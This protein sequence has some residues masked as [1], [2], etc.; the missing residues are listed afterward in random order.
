MIII[1]VST[2]TVFYSS[3]AAADRSEKPEETQKGSH[4][5]ADHSQFKILQQNFKSGPGVTE[6][7]LTCHTEAAEQV[8]NSI[9]WSWELHGKTGE[10][11]GKKTVINNFCIGITSNEPRCTS[12]H[13]GYGWSDS[14]FDFNKETSVDCLVCHDTTGSYKK[15]PT[16]AGHPL[17]EPEKWKGKT[18]QPPQLGKIAR[19]VGKTGRDTCGACHFYG[20]GGDG[21]KHG[22]LDSSLKKPSPS[23]DVHMSP[24]TENFSCSECHIT[25]DHITEGSHYQMVAKDTEGKNPMRDKKG[26]NTCESCHG[27]EP[28]TTAKLNH[29]VEKVACQS[30][31][32]PEFA[33]KKPTKM[34]WDWSTAGRMKDGKPFG[35]KNEKGH[36]IYHSKKGSFTWGEN[37]VPEYHWFNGDM[38]YLTLDDKINPEEKPVP[39][40]R[41]GGSYDDKGSRLWPF[42]VHKG[43]QAY[44]KK[45]KTLLLPKLFGKKGSGAFWASYDWQKA[46]DKG[47]KEA[48]YKFS[49]EIGWVDTAM[50]WPI[51]HMVAPAEDSVECSECHSRDGRLAGVE[52]FYLPGRD[53]YTLIEAGGWI[54]VLLTLAGVGWH[55]TKRILSNRGEK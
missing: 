28:H 33:R 3:L 51:T 11:P 50:Y 26:A 23:L 37:V 9:H 7:C 19:N 40:N 5:T 18:K 6:A 20:G 42:K 8:Q 25:R 16:A 53:R 38:N 32:I 30:C 29:H 27:L 43:R 54:M 2:L 45:Y 52:G 13:A 41:L 34:S 36:L 55:A 49:G 14:G 15:F 44:D 24:E 22:D 35:K 46:F 31:H 10:M 17:Y 39:I 21:V 1:L 12:C 47:M 4:S 48:G